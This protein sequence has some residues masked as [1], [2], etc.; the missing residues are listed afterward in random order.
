MSINPSD[1]LINSALQQA[2]NLATDATRELD[3]LGHDSHTLGVDRAEVGILEQAH[4]VGLAGL[5]KCQNG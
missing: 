5:L 1:K 4:K 3:V 2:T